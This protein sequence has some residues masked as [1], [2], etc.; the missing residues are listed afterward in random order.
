MWENKK[1]RKGCKS[2]INGCK[3]S[4]ERKAAWWPSG[5]QTPYLPVMW[6]LPK[7][8]RGGFF[9]AKSSQS[10][11]LPAFLTSR[12]FLMGLRTG[13]EKAYSRSWYHLWA[14]P[15]SWRNLKIEALEITWPHCHDSDPCPVSPWPEKPWIM[16]KKSQ[17]FLNS[18]ETHDI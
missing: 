3:E 1:E 13:K 16:W 6:Y 17:R 15:H 5:P 11:W 14:P 4:E 7:R 12:G 9:G 10:R 2:K 18:M 8:W